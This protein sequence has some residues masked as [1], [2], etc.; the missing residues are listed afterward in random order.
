MP[1]FLPHEEES[2]LGLHHVLNFHEPHGT[3]RCDVTHT[4]RWRGARETTIVS[5]NDV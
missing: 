4:L 3:L 2:R 5:L 1:T